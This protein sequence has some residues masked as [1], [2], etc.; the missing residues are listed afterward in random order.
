MPETKIIVRGY[1][2]NPNQ[3]PAGA[4]IR[5]EGEFPDVPF[6]QPHA[7]L[8]EQL[9]NRFGADAQAIVDILGNN[10]PGGTMHQLL[11]KLLQ[12]QASLYVVQDVPD[13]TVRDIA[14]AARSFVWSKHVW[15]TYQAGHLDNAASALAALVENRY[16]P[17]PA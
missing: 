6:D 16:G 11:I 10:L 9:V 8:Q 1:K 3:A 2:A 14:E 12:R 15:H 13:T 7:D 5:I 17:P 4:V